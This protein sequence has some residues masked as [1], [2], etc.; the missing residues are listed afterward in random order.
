MRPDRS[1]RLSASCRRLLASVRGR[2]LLFVASLAPG[3][4]LAVA[5]IV[6]FGEEPA[7]GALGLDEDVAAMLFGIKLDG[8]FVDAEGLDEPFHRVSSERN[9]A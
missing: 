9:I 4:I 6:G 2:R 7:F 1:S 8:V 3:V 5:A